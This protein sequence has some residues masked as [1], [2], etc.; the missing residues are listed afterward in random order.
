MEQI[1]DH[2]KACSFL[3]AYGKFLQGRLHF[4]YMQRHGKH[5]S[6]ESRLQ[7][8]GSTGVI[9]RDPP[10]IIGPNPSTCISQP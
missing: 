8:V 5:H 6:P 7:D 4:Y 1:P 2:L 9:N 10:G 3:T